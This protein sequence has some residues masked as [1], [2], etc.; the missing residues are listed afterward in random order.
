MNTEAR[1]LRVLIVDDHDIVRRG[2]RSVLEDEEGIVVG[3]EAAPADRRRCEWR[4]R[5]DPTSP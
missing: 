4:R 5:C 2:L 3:G 1:N